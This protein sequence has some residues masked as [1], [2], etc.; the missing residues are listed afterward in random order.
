MLGDATPWADTTTYS[1]AAALVLWLIALGLADRRRRARATNQPTL[2]GNGQAQR[3]L[4]RHNK[5][6]LIIGGIRWRWLSCWR[7][8]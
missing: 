3:F 4:L 1:I 6:G 7:C 5:S 2:T 8:C